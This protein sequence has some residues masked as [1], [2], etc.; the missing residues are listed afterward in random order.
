MPACPSPQIKMGLARE[1]GALAST[2]LHEKSFGVNGSTRWTLRCAENLP[3][4]IDA[5]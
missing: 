2:T 3:M 1:V 5:Y 4:Q